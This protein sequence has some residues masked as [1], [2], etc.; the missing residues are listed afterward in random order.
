MK[1]TLMTTDGKFW[2]YDELLKKMDDDNFY[3]GYL[4][5]YALSSSSVKKLLDSPKAYIKS[6]RQRDDTPALLQG[7]LVHL[8]VLE[9]EKFQ[10]LNFVDVQSRNTKAFKEALSQ[11]SET[12]TR[13]EYNNAMYLAEAVANNK[14]ATELLDGTKKE[15]PAAGMLF[16]KPFRA[17]ADALGSGRIVDLKTCQN[18]NKFHWSAKDYK[19]MCQAY[20]YCQLFNVDYTDFFYIAVDKGTNDI[21]IFDMSEEFYNLGES[22][23]EQAVEV[24]T[25]EIQNGMNELHNYT[26]RGTL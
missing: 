14:H 10:E 1:D 2:E 18:I 5:K 6:L 8:A 17:K 16:G 3:Y 23:V 15:V 26:I 7:K 19:Y 4:G 25:N 20:I 9:P 22:L 13:K 21:G 24:Y 12:Y 11:N